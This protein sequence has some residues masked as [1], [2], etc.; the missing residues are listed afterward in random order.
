VGSETFVDEAEIFVSSGAGGPG[1]VHFRREK[2]VPYGGPD[3][4]DGGSG[5]SVF[6][7][8]DRNEST[9][10][11]FRSRRRFEA[12]DGERGGSSRSTGADGP[13][14]EIRVPLGTMVFDADEGEDAPP[15]VDLAADGQRFVVARGGRGGRGNTRFKTATHQTP[16]FAQDG[17]P[18]ESRTLRLSLKLL[19][20]VGLVGFPN[21]GKSTL[22]RA[23][24][25]AKPR[26]AS[27]PFTTLVPSLG[28]VEQGERRFVVA[29]I[30][31][32]IEGASEGVGLG[33]RFLR[34]VER[35]R[36]LVHL[37]D[38]GAMMLEGR[39]PLADYG[40]LRTELGRYRPELLERT[41]IVLLNKTD[42]VPEEHT[43]DVNALA[44]T[45]AARG[46]AVLR[47]SGATGQGMRELVIAL[48]RTLDQLEKHEREKAES[49]RAESER[50]AREAAAQGESA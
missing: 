29:D 7:I 44:A 40:A 34:H 35:T 25:A 24:S 30:P 11:S 49:E 28:V 15:L 43:G 16:D 50:R 42:L 1:V 37:I 38:L 26:V 10:L 14:V 19:A 23:I 45:L 4:G 32:L 5:G 13:D 12:R 41:E 31:G 17:L 22:I 9:L 47:G 46:R 39:D 8:A 20:D 2:Y 36:V 33:D 27:Y 18:G 21:A 6:L 48:A 3:G